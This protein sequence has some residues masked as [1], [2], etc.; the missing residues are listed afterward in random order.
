MERQKIVTESCVQPQKKEDID[1]RNQ[2]TNLSVRLSG[3]LI[4][5]NFNKNSRYN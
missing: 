4:A 5:E 1:E 2:R 3:G